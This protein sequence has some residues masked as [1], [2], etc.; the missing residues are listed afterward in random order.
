MS[1]SGK[2]LGLPIV[3]VRA[4]GIDI[5]ARIQVAAVPPELS[6]DPVRTFGSFTAD[7]EQMANWLTSIGI[8]TVAMESTGV[9]WVPVY[10]IL[11]AHGLTVVLANARD[12]KAVPG[13][14]SDVNDA[15]WLQRL[16]ACGLLRASFHPAPDIAA[17]RA[18]TRIR[19]RHLEYAAAH[20]QHMQK[21]LTL[22]NLQLH[23]VLSDISGVTG[24]KII[25]AI[26]SGERDPDVLASMRDV[27]CRESLQTIRAALVGNYQPEHVF[28]LAQ[29]LALFDSYQ[30]RIGDCDRQIENSLR[31]LNADRPKPQTPLRAARIRTKQANA[32]K[33]DVRALLYQLTGTDLTLIH[34]LGP[35]LALS[36]VAECG[37]NLGKWPS[38]KHFASWLC[39][40]PGCKI[41]GGKVLSARTRR[42][43]SR[44]TSQL[45]LAA[46]N[47]G[48]TET[49]LGAFY[50]RLAARV[51]KAKAVTATARKLAI[52]FYR[53]MRFGMQYQDPG[54]D[55]YEQRY[56]E[57]VVRQLERRAA[58]FGFSLQPAA[59]GVS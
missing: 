1:K 14:K 3:N 33:F 48:R 18:Y 34:G 4:A 46:T 24:L 38:E 6:D 31:A 15:Q 49:A 47:V 5:G 29:A 58:R 56:R 42:G 40:S 27:R 28:A 19:E 39:L 22:M 44:L 52:L 54:V 43:S 25:R 37:T 26:V 10:E 2:A 13:R 50:R 45:R 53:A 12:C 51:G 17:L 36:L 7:I 35:S 11:E 20:M 16:H 23:H 30:D 9:Y 32:P 57:R 41:S 59:G 55:Q 21:A 8:T